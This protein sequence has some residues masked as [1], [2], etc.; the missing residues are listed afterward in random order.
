MRWLDGITNSMNMSLSKL[1]EIVK[2]REAMVCPWGQ[3]ELDMTQS[4]NNHS[5]KCWLC[6]QSAWKVLGGQWFAGSAASMVFHSDFIA[7]FA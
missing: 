4:L 6:E 7:A 3:K 5:S 2:D 1:L